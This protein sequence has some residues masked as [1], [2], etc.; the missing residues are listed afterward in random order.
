MKNNNRWVL[1][2][3][4]IAVLSI[5]VTIKYFKVAFPEASLD[6]NI[7]KEK[8]VEIAD[9]FISLLGESTDGYMNGIILDEDSKA[10]NFFDR[11]FDAIYLDSVY[12]TGVKVWFWNVRWFRPLKKKEFSVYINPSYGN[13]EGYERIINEEEV[14]E[15]ITLD[16][17]RTIA[18]TFLGNNRIN[19]D[20]FI[21]IEEGSESIKDKEGNLVR[22]D[23]NFVWEKK[24]WNIKEAKYRLNVKIQGDK[25]GNYSEWVKVPEKWDMKFERERSY[26]ELTRQIAN[27]FA[28]ILLLFAGFYFFV[29]LKEKNIY[30]KVSTYIGIFVFVIV[31]L[32]TINSFPLSV[33]NF[34][35]TTESYS[36]FY[37]R[38][39]L[40]ALL[41]SL[42]SGL[43]VFL[44]CATGEVFYRNWLKDKVFLPRLFTLDGFKTR[45]ATYSVIIG[46]LFAIIH[47]GFVTVFY[48]L[49]KKVGFWTPT[50][51]SYTDAINTRFPWLFALFAFSPAFLEE[52]IFRL[53][54]VPFLKKFTKSIII[55]VIISSFLFGFLHSNYPQQPFF[56]RGIEVGIIAIFAALLMIR[57]GI[58]SAITWHYAVDAFLM[59]LFLFRS[60]KPS[61]FI[62]GL[63]SVGIFFIPIILLFIRKKKVGDE[64][65]YNINYEKKEERLEEKR[66][67]IAKPTYKPFSKNKISLLFIS[68][69]ILLIGIT[70][71]FK[72]K[73]REHVKITRSEARD[74][75]VSYIEEKGIDEEKLRNVTYLWVKDSDAEVNYM[76]RNKGIKGLKNFLDSKPSVL[77]VTRFFTP[78]EK[79]EFLVRLK[80]SDGDIYSFTHVLPEEKKGERLTEEDA[81]KIAFSYLEEK[82]IN[83]SEIEILK[84][85]KE[86][87]E[88]RADYVL[89][90]E[91][92][93]KI[94]DISKRIELVIQ[95]NEVSGFRDYF[96]IPED[97]QR[98]Y[99][100]RTAV[101]VIK[102]FLFGILWGIAVFLLMVSFVKLIIRGPSDFRRPL[103]IAGI[104]VFVSLIN[105][106]N[107]FFLS[108]KDY[109]TSN[110][111]Q[112]FI[113]T[114]TTQ[115]IISLIVIFAGVF[116]LNYICLG[117][118][119][120]NTNSKGFILSNG[121]IRDGSVS[122]LFGGLLIL[123]FLYLTKIL[124]LYLR[125][126]VNNVEFLSYPSFDL[127]I[128][129]LS[130]PSSTLISTFLMFP[131][132]VS[133]YFSIQESFK[134]DWAKYILILLG[135][136][137]I[138][139]E[140]EKELLASI[141]I[142]I[143]NIILLFLAF[144]IVR[145][146]LKDNMLSY[147]IGIS[148]VYLLPKVLMYTYAG[149]NYYILSGIFSVVFYF[150]LIYLI[151]MFIRK[152][153]Y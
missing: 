95:G 60:G 149:S 125:I 13:I 84:K 102:L 57:F 142:V 25:I 135:I 96:K 68:S 85:E 130:V 100:K 86:E 116:T 153:E 56:A 144:I 147:I 143:S 87:K 114:I 132:I 65:L 33:V 138:S 34:Y 55:A 26:N 121:Y 137:I 44:T 35:E 4:L 115:Y 73:P 77:W 18:I 131:F 150:I 70:F 112:N 117:S 28:V 140:G 141:Y 41:N 63:I 92:K 36:G 7:E 16:S 67:E 74:I 75:S 106:M 128:P 32:A 64:E 152:Y 113:G 10:K 9:E 76:F 58:L 126:P 89:Q 139:I 136:I 20:N 133:L 104:V 62:A 78:L 107:R 69:L 93:E 120:K 17:A 134:K 123:L 45:E 50:E 98:D 46:Y 39:I 101:N 42:M 37:L 2:F 90:F 72:I 5:F 3:S 119:R 22:I 122:G 80:P 146:M 31:L 29:F 43:L 47:I 6:I 23:H 94:G 51:I 53:F 81:L 124:I 105:I 27:V 103:I 24:G 59:G 91:T 8:A 48:L 83:T 61:F 79:E 15:K 99:E 30:F 14:G 54:A 127:Y 71:L 97:W 148:I 40:N 21:V 38:Y 108:F 88:N 82:G 118:F 1:I 151:V 52:F 66:E 129:F 109:Q 145:Y 11:E 111:L 19:L 12:R 110:P 49:G